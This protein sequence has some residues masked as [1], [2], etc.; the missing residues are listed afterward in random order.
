MIVFFR[1]GPACVCIRQS[2]SQLFQSS[3]C[4]FLLLIR[5]HFETDKFGKRKGR[6]RRIVGIRRNNMIY[7]KLSATSV[8]CV[9]NLHIYFSQR[10]SVCESLCKADEQIYLSIKE[11]RKTHTISSYD[12]LWCNKHIIKSVISY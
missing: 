3:S 5:G 9:S 7:N 6:E 2:L 12:I 4:L 1:V 8:L 11:K 10:D